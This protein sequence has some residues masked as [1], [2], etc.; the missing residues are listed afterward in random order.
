M[1][2]SEDHKPLGSQLYYTYTVNC[3]ET[4]GIQWQ[5]LNFEDLAVRRMHALCKAQMHRYYCW[6]LTWPFTCTLQIFPLYGSYRPTS[7]YLPVVSMR[8]SQAK[9]TVHIEILVQSKLIHI[10]M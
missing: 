2:Q 4:I 5:A 10:C 1:L 9:P 6:N 8:G 7:T 3:I